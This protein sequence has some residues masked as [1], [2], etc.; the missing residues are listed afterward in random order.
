MVALREDP[1]VPTGEHAEL[2]EEPAAEALRI[3]RRVRHVAFERNAVV[4]IVGEARGL[5]VW[6]LAPSAQINAFAAIFSPP[7]RASIASLISSSV[8]P[9]RKSAPV[10][11][12][13]SARKW[14]RSAALCQQDERLVGRALEVVLE[15]EPEGEPGRAVLDHGVDGERQLTYG[16]SSAAAAR[17]VAWEGRSVDQKDARPLAA[18]PVGGGRACGPAPTIKT[19]NLFI[20][21]AGYRRAA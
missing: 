18:E 20:V 2:E 10:S 19:S 4:A 7:T 11:A 8:T 21:D 15:V 17:L 5:A 13:R 12:A 9:S 6:P 14:S 16:A 3:D 1:A